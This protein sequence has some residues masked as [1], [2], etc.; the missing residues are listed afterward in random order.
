VKF[1]QKKKNGDVFLKHSVHWFTSGA[2]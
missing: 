2:Y 1:S